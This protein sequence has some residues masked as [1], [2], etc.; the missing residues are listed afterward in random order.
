MTSIPQMIPQNKNI[1]ATG[2]LYFAPFP[3]NCLDRKNAIGNAGIKYA[4]GSEILQVQ[5]YPIATMQP[6]HIMLMTLSMNSITQERIVSL[7]FGDSV[8]LS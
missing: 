1:I 6:M 5:P 4:N 7:S 2:I 3:S 8:M